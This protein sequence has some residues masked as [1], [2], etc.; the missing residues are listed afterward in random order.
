M[1][2]WMDGQINTDH[3]CPSTYCIYFLSRVINTF[4]FVGNTRCHISRYKTCKHMGMAMF[5]SNF[6]L[7]KQ[8]G[9]WIY[10]MG[11]MLVF[12]PLAYHKT[13]GNQMVP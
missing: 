11:H 10:P 5:Q 13:V 6:Y 9:S 12:Q 4:G 3:Y 7:Q 1:D 8:A 2:G